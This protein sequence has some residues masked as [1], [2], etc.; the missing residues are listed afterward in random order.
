[1]DRWGRI[2]TA[3]TVAKIGTVSGA[4]DALGYHRA[5]VI[6]HIDLLESEIGEKLFLRHDRGYSTTDVGRDLLSAG[7]AAEGIFE[8]FFQRTASHA[9][10]FE[11]PLTISGTRITSPLLLP[12][13]KRFRKS[14]PA[15][16]CRYDIQPCEQLEEHDCSS[17]QYGGAHI[18]VVDGIA[19]TYPDYIVRPFVTIR[20]G[21]YAAQAY[22]DVYGKPSSVE[23]F[24]EHWFVCADDPENCKPFAK[25]RNTNIPPERW[26]LISD[27]GT[28]VKEHL[29]SGLGIGFC[30][31]HE[32]QQ[33]G[34]VEI[35]SPKSEWD[36][37]CWL[38]T[39]R[40]MHRSAKVSAFLEHVKAHYGR[41]SPLAAVQSV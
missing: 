10:S 26:A 29:F 31:E 33:Q 36:W 7:S 19:P 12:A 1:M 15:V 34:L 28:C 13:I 32:A 35:I 3:Y 39:H 37:P 4:A 21:L 11:G 5:T 17:L 41:P 23:E 9:N 6:R 18:A 2:R 22:L 14:N 38:V 24:K 20:T 30:P 16:Q 25:W 40:D 8:D 27:N